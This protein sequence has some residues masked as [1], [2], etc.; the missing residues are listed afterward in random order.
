MT[1]LAQ[2]IVSGLLS[3]GVYA[4]VAVGLMQIFGVMELVNFAQGDFMMVCMYATFLLWQIGGLD[5]LVGLPVA[6]V[7]GAI[8]GILTYFILIRRILDAPVI[9]QLVVTLGLSVF[10]EGSAQ[11]VFG[12]STRS[13]VNPLLNSVSVHLGSVILPGP[14]LVATIVAVLAMGAI[15]WFTNE[16]QLGAAMSAVAEDRDAAQLIGVDPHRVYI[17]VWAVSGALVGVAGALLMSF[18][19]VTPDIGIAFILLAFVIVVLGGFGSTFGALLAAF[20]VGIVQSVVGFALPGYGLAAVFA[21]YC[22]AVVAR[23]R[24]LLGS[25]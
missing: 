10:L 4:L 25:R 16:T 19:P 13:V 23:P 17:L 3:G 5:P 12:P 7:V 6:A 9:S 11:V 22:V 15:W 14:Q 1:A 21:L 8:V 18:F 24:G 2:T 20:G